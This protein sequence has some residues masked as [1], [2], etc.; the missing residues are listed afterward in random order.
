ME[1]IRISVRNLVEFILNSGDIDNRKGGMADQEAMQIGSR[2]HRKIQGQMGGGYRAEVSL[3]YSREFMAEK[4]PYTLMIEGRA[5]GIFQ[6][7]EQTVIDEIKGIYRPVQFLEEPLAVHQAQAACYACIY[8]MEQG[9]S[10]ISVQMTYCNLESEE[11]KRFRREYEMEE[12]KEWFDSLISE[13]RK[14]CVFQILW[15]TKR[16]ESIPKIRFPFAYREG[17]R[18][19]AAAVYRTIE[20]KKKIFIQ[21]P[22]GVGKTISTIFPAVKALGEG[23]G[24]K[25]FYLTA[26]TITRTVAWETFTLLKQQGL[27]CKVLVLTAKEKICPLEETDCNPVHC[28]YAKGHYDRVNNAV[29]EMLNDTD[30]FSREAIL[31]QSEEWKVCPFEM[32]LDLALWMDVVICDYNYVFDPTAHLKRFF[33]DNVKGSYL[34]L[35]D[36]AHNLVER[37]REMYSAVLYKEDFLEARRLVKEQNGKL[38]GQLSRVNRLFLEWKRECEGCEVL[39]SLGSL[40]TALMSLEGILEEYLEEVPH[41]EERKGL[42]DLYFQIRN[43]LGIYDRLD[44]S[45]LIYDRIT[46]DGRFLIKLFCVDT[47]ANIQECLNKGNSTVFFSATLLPVDYYKRLLSQETEDYAVYAKTPFSA[48]QRLVIIGRDVSSRYKRRGP[49]EYERIAGYI[50]KTMAQKKGNYLVF[51]PSYQMMEDVGRVFAQL[52]GEEVEILYQQAGMSE[53]EREAFLQAFERPEEGEK[54]SLAGFCVMG[55]IFGEGIDLKGERLIGSV[56]V[57][58]GLPKVCEERELLKEYYNGRSMDG[59]AYAYRIPGM[60]KVLQ[61]AG[62]VIRT[63]QDRGVILLLDERFYS[64]EYWAMFPREWQDLKICTLRDVE[65]KVSEFWQR[66]QILP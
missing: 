12:L 41:G 3:K 60:N 30:D 40:P 25:I 11:I 66:D 4:I 49:R 20:R 55:G 8:G 64:E 5:D 27:A 18:E 65:E 44:D 9:L 7:G 22:T 38:A 19:L 34:F 33:G 62:R 61:S 42:L 54:K 14:W 23:L 51:F 58:T 32:S 63:A 31:K 43:F 21:A 17:Q 35:I 52:A 53:E 28:P 39:K 29:F 45:Y 57:G 48:E 16:Q 2:L 56:I 6:E 50:Q 36:E 59:F 26:K 13:Y 46:E 24:E 15:N 47:A 10:E 1:S 37:G